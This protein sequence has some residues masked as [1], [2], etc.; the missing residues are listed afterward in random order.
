MLGLGEHV[1]RGEMQRAALL[2]V[3]Q[4]GLDGGAEHHEQVAGAGEAVDADGGGQLVLGLLH[5]QVAGADDDVDALHGV[6]AVGERGDGLRAAHAVHALDAAQPAGAEDGGV[7]LPIGPGRRAHGDV[8]DA[9]GARGDDAHDDGAGVGGAPPGDVDGGGADGHLAQED[10]L[11]L[12]Q[13]DGHVAPDAGVGDEGDVDDGDLQAGDELERQAFD[14]L[15]ELLGGDEQR[16]LADLRSV[17]AGGVEAARVVEHGGV[18]PGAHVG[19][20]LA[21]GP[22][23][24][25]AVWHER[26]HARGGAGGSAEAGDVVG[27]ETLDAHVRPDRAR[28]ARARRRATRAA[29][30]T[31]RRSRRP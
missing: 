19:D 16:A 21:H 31:A 30:P 20:D 15:V 26:A 7:D 22:G 28:R 9:G 24:G 2:P 1:Q 3:I 17:A 5:V 6:G 13:L 29:C 12:G 4:L 23:D 18:A 25:V 8:D 10:A 27:A 11:S 14:G